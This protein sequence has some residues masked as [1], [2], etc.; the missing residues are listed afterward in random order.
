[1]AEVIIYAQPSVISEFPLD[2][3][4]DDDVIWHQQHFGKPGQV[5]TGQ[6]NLKG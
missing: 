1:M 3:F 2:L 6:F 4:F 5:A